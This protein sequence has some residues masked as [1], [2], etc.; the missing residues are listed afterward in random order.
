M[1]LICWFQE[2]IDDPLSVRYGTIV[3]PEYVRYVLVRSS[4]FERICNYRYLTVI[5]ET[6]V[7]KFI[8]CMFFKFKYGT[9]NLDTH[10]VFVDVDITFS[11][12]EFFGLICFSFGLLFLKWNHFSND[13]NSYF[14]VFYSFERGTYIKH[15]YL[16]D[17]KKWER[18]TYF[19]VWKFIPLEKFEFLWYY[20]FITAN[21]FKHI[22][23]LSE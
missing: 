23:K 22:W 21:I 6:Y 3:Q 10:V 9:K 14:F 11:A 2:R 19:R 7:R 18:F 12:K 16:C 17:E 15:E 13:I 20:L 4:F 5:N 8:L 1:L